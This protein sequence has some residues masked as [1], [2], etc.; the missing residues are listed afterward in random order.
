MVKRKL[1]QKEKEL[2]KK[3]IEK[4]EKE[5]R[6]ATEKINTIKKQQEFIKVKRE[7]EDYLRPYNRKIEDK[8][9]ADELKKAEAELEWSSRDLKNLKKQLKEGVEEKIPCNV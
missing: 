2:C 8:Q 1:K 3:G 7:H 6:E 4:R 5:V 9:Y